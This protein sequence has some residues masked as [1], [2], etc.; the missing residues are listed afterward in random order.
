MM[1]YSRR[2]VC[3]CVVLLL[4]FMI[5]APSAALAEASAA[6]ESSPPFDLQT[7]S[8]LLMEAETG[9]VIF[10]HNAD[11][12]RP[13]AS[14]TKLMPILLTLEE[15]DR[16]VVKLSDK[17]HCSADAA[18]MGGSQALL[19]ANVLYSLEDLFKSM[20]IASANDSAVAIAEYLNGSEDAFVK[21][22]NDRAAQL[23][24]T[25]TNYKNVT[26]LPVD[27]QYTTA[28]DVAT[29]SREV[30][31]HPA[32]YQYSTIWMYSLTHPSGRTTDLTNTNRLIRFYEG[33]DGFKTGSTNEARYCLS[34]TAKRGD[35]R[36]IAVV[37]GTPASQTRFDDAR[38]MLE[39]GFAN[40]QL[41]RVA[42]SGDLLGAEVPVR[43]GARSAV[44]A[45]IGSDVSL[46]L[47]K[48][49][50]R[51]LAIEATLAESLAAP[52]RKGD[53]IGEVKVTLNGDTVM[54]IPAVAAVDV[55]Y[56]GFIEGVM[57]V[58]RNWKV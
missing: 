10:E 31:K 40:Y 26:G 35:T 57:T 2:G 32:Y 55:P 49:Q 56:P 53:P 23:G 48:G 4:M 16:G 24:M 42:K 21:R 5:V 12:R 29:L 43:L 3:V 51:N 27:G 46:L 1:K 28:R 47:N 15:L 17:V 39:Y 37:L 6:L 36:M 25:N 34:A 33:A 30:A 54:T 13:V 8:Y 7:P 58:L 50:E 52:I 20:V 19:D 41:N 11:E 44:P 9:W 45:A 18:G 22:M 38:K 14:V